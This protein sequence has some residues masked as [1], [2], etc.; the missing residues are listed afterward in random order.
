MKYFANLEKLSIEL[1]ENSPNLEQYLYG[2]ESGR[3]ARWNEIIFLL[4]LCHDTMCAQ[5]S[6][7]DARILSRKPLPNTRRVKEIEFLIASILIDEYKPNTFGEIYALRPRPHASGV[8]PFRSSSR[9]DTFRSISLLIGRDPTRMERLDSSIKPWKYV[10]MFDDI[11]SRRSRKLLEL[12]SDF[13]LIYL[14]LGELAD[15][16]H[17]IDI[18]R[19]QKLPEWT[20]LDS[21]DT[22]PTEIIMRKGSPPRSMGEDT[23]FFCEPFHK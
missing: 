3:S 6:D 4:K 5:A 2:V 1:K 10:E 16:K 18:F 23:I 12:S 14:A 7:T 8:K 13:Y 9:L 21:S 22:P 15:L 17:T 19:R 20:S 11:G